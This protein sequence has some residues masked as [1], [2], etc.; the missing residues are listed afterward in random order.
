MVNK[1]QR[2]LLIFLCG[3]VLL[4]VIAVLLANLG[5]P[6]KTETTKEFAK[7]G[8]GAV[9][10]EI[11]GLFIIVTRGIFAQ[12]SSIYSLVIRSPEELPGLDITRIEWDLKN[13]FMKFREEKHLIKPALSPVGPAWEIRLPDA[14]HR[15]I[16][17][18]DAVELLLTDVRGNTWRVPP[19]FL[20]QRQLALSS[21]GERQKIIAHYGEKDE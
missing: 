19:F 20:F 12:K 7:W 21:M 4:T 6:T 17:E 15:R 16:S 14:I 5:F 10:A 13:C 11:I 18:T 1:T 9:L 8:L 3:V 2:Y